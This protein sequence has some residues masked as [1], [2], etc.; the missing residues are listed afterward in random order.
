MILIVFLLLQIDSLSIS[1]WY[2]IEKI[3]T[4]K[5]ERNN[6]IVI[7]TT[8]EN[9]SFVWFS[10]V[11]RDTSAIFELFFFKNRTS[12][13]IWRLH[14]TRSR[15]IKRNASIKRWKS[16]YVVFLSNVMKKIDRF[17][18]SKWSTHWISQKMH[19]SMRFLLKYCM[20]SSREKNSQRSRSFSKTIKTF[21]F[22]SK[23]AQSCAKKYT[24]R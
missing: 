10:I 20:K 14:F 7:F 16:S 2:S 3:E 12:S 23:D 18:F 22:L 4:R 13:S 11:I 19:L 5:N 8:F 9:Y 1:N 21:C 17:S 24:T 15:M 6:I